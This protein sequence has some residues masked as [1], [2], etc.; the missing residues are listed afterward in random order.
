MLLKPADVM[1]LQQTRWGG[2]K[3]RYMRGGCRLFYSGG[4]HARHGVGI[5]VNNHQDKVLEVCRSPDRVKAVKWCCRT[6]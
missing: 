4:K 1:C 5:C 2:Y 3:A 6:M